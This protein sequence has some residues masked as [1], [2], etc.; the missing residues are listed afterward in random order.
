MVVND[1]EGVT[2]YDDFS[3]NLSSLN[4]LPRIIV[5]NI[6]NLIKT[7][8][9]EFSPDVTF[10]NGQIVDLKRYFAHNKDVSSYMWIVPKY[11]LNFNLTDTSMGFKNYTLNINTDKYGQIIDINWPRRGYD[12]K[13][14]FVSRDSIKK[15]ALAEA[16]RLNFNLINYKVDFY[17]SKRDE[18]FLWQFLFPVF[19]EPL[20][21]LPYNCIEI[22]WANIGDSKTYQVNKA[23]YN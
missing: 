1:H 7:S 2:Y 3:K 16:K 23:S 11:D 5:Y 12:H 19:K 18:K 8:M 21:G 17:Y 15:F 22:N 4:K 13:S 10:S 9:G 14:V 20:P 6:Q